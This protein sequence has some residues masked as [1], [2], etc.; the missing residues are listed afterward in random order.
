MSCDATAPKV[1]YKPVPEFPG[2]RVGSDGSVWSCWR[3]DGFVK[4]AMGNTWRRLKPGMTPN[5]YH[6]VCLTREKKKKYWRVH[7][8][9]CFVFHG[10]CPVGME[11]AHEN[12]VKADCRADN[13]KWKTRKANHADKN[14]H[15]TSN[16]GERHGAHKL[17]WEAVRKIRARSAAGESAKSIA[18]SFSVRRETVGYVIRGQTWKE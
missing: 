9:V 11:A 18:E 5:G 1:I 10:P 3:K 4:W 13:L 6:F 17:T 16:A 8:L 7:R 12:G 15:G 2:Y 14:R